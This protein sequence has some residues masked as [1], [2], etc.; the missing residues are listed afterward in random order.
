MGRH[1]IHPMIPVETAEIVLS[2]VLVVG[3][4][5]VEESAV[6]RVQ[7]QLRSRGFAAGPGNHFSAEEAL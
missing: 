2:W 3:F 7:R 4:A 1:L 5:E 6:V